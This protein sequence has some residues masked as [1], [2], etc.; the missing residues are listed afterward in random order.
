MQNCNFPSIILLTEHWLKPNEPVYIPNYSVLSL[1]SRTNSIHGG[2]LIL[3]NNTIINSL[4]FVSINKYDNLL[5]EKVFEFSIA[6]CSKINMYII[7]IYRSPIS[8]VNLFLNKLETLLFGLPTKSTTVLTGDFNINFSDKESTDRQTLANLLTCFNL[9]MHVN[10]YTRVSQYSSTTID[11]FCTNLNKGVS[12]SIVSPG[13]SDHEAVYCSLEIE[14]NITTNNKYKYGRLYSKNNYNRFFQY[15]LQCDWNDILNRD[16]SLDDF[17]KCL[18]YAFSKAFPIQKIKI[19][20]KKP[21]LTRGIKTSAKN[22]RNLH[23]I[24]KYTQE[25]F[26][27]EYYTKYRNIYKKVIKTAKENYFNARLNHANNKSKE[28]WAII[29]ELR[30]K[31]HCSTKTNINPNDL[32][33]YYCSIADK[34]TENIIPPND[35]LSYM[36]DI[37]NNQTLCLYDTNI[38]ELKEVI[39][40]IKNKNAS[41][42]DEMSIKIFENLPDVTLNVLVYLI[43]KSF[44]MGI[45]P[46]FLKISLVIPLH[47]GGDVD[48]PSNYRPIS[49]IPTLAKIIEKLVKKRVLGFLIS[50]KLLSSEQFGFQ[51]NKSTNDAMFSFLYR[52]YTELNMGEAAAAIFCDLSKAFDC[53]QHEILLKKLGHYGFR[54]VSLEWFNSYLSGREQIVT[55]STNSKKLNINCGVP[56]GSVLGPILF[57]LY[58]NDL[59]KIDI[60][61]EFTLFADDT[62][63]LWHNK[64]K[65]ILH[66]IICSD[67]NKVKDWC[68][69][70]L[71][72]FNID[73]TNIM[74]F[75]CSLP[76]IPLG[77]HVLQNK[78]CTK[79]LGLHIDLKLKFEEHIISISNKLA[80]GCYAVRVVSNEL[81]YTAAKAVYFSLIESHLTYGISFWGVCSKYLMQMIF[82]LQKRAIRYLCKARARDS[83]K[84]LFVTHN[85]L[86]VTSIFIRET[87]VLIHKNKMNQS[88]PTS[89]YATRQ[90]GNV[91]LP[92][93]RSTLV[94]DSIVYNGQKMYNHLPYDIKNMNSI[95]NFKNAVKK[96]LIVKAYYN[97]QEY[98]DDA[99]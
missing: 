76:D 14:S 53:V 86:T 15:C 40:E 82:V 8:D 65:N 35:P 93:P 17:Y 87:V 97:L 90:V 56:Q 29:N 79:F 68:D 37:N 18:I 95:K 63:I 7:C 72:S 49:L 25:V 11:Y 98:Y 57:L 26:F 92:I 27:F 81:G 94:K 10:S 78:T 61:G 28:S 43:N 91:T 12:C 32:N 48:D 30:G 67:I 60:A 62:T 33:N 19:K 24:R 44:Q 9:N 58:I 45:F 20:K 54:G 6:F 41:G 74:P 39:K 83:C 34:L 13:L 51:C 70:N 71:L 1:F 84:P 36:K 16:S 80:S 88:I 96:L 69:S 59:T 21:W 22:L 73:K 47:K 4:P 31:D 55:N 23:Y 2:T 3:L 89:N 99:L 38:V 75:R 52:V 46:S 64:D 50:S 85:V 77:N 42:I 66:E 5:E